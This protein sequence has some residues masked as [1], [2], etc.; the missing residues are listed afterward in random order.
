MEVGAIAALPSVGARQQ[1]T[2]LSA[3]GGGCVPTQVNFRLN[4]NV[5]TRVTVFARA[6]KLEVATSSTHMQ[7]TVTETQAQ[8]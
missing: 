5:C 6:S 3:S 2:P 7:P 8:A 4:L 1:H